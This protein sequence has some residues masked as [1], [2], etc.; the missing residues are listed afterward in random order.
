MMEPTLALWSRYAVQNARAVSIYNEHGKHYKN[1]CVFGRN[2]SKGYVANL[3]RSRCEKGL[4]GLLHSSL[5]R[6]LLMHM[7]G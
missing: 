7:A 1:A 5:T 4:L 2:L 6:F 3:C